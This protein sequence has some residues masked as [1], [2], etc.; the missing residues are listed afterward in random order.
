MTNEKEQEV[1]PV[2][3]V[4]SS[5]I[6]KEI[7]QTSKKIERSKMSPELLQKIEAN[8]KPIDLFQC[9]LCENYFRS[10]A[11]F[12][13]HFDN[14]HQV[15]KAERSDI[16]SKLSQKITKYS[17]GSTPKTMTQCNL[18]DKL[19]TKE[20]EFGVHLTDEHVEA[21]DVRIK[22]LESKNYD[23][24]E[25]L[26]A[27]QEEREIVL[28]QREIK[29]EK[30]LRQKRKRQAKKHQQQTEMTKKETSEDESITNNEIILDET[31]SHVQDQSQ[32]SKLH[33]F[34]HGN[35]EEFNSKVIKD[36]IQL[37]EESNV[38]DL[39]HANEVIVEV[40]NVEG[41]TGIAGTS[42][43]I[44][45]YIDSLELEV[46]CLKVSQQFFESTKEKTSTRTKT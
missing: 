17:N 5:D 23:V 26:T 32:D 43:E 12:R 8:I 11:D 9:T 14:V 20:M 19:F 33:T 7:P 29:Y 45:K 39:E 1:I 36:S 16:Y 18:C 22:E 21:I 34:E 40:P 35:E 27:M 25:A 24:M 28:K 2:N 3:V 41:A 31:I 15:K 46:R 42:T 38:Q 6:Q 10:K 37:A 30:K 13:I 4:T 44:S